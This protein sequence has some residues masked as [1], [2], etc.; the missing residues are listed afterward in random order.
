MED[1]GRSTTL[2]DLPLDFLTA[3]CQHIDVRDVVRVGATCKRLRHGEGGLETVELPTKSPVFTALHAFSGGELMPSTRPNGCSDSW[4]AYL[5]R[6]A[7][8]RRYQEA[9]P[10]A[11]GLQRSLAVDA[12]GRLMACG[13]TLEEGDAAGYGRGANRV[14][15]FT[16]VA[17][18]A[19]FRV[20]SVAAGDKHSLALGWDGRVLAWGTNGCGQLGHVDQLDRPTPALVAGL[21]NVRSI[22]AASHH[23]L[24]ATQSGAV[25]SWGAAVQPGAAD[26]L[27][28]RI[29][30]G[31]EGVRV[32]R[33]YAGRGAAFATGEAREVF[34]WGVGGC[35]RLGHGDTQDQPS[36]ERVEALRGVRVSSIAIGCS[37]MRWL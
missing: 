2:L 12:T 7:R 17:V 3:V 15:T 21:D 27:R 6:C 1:D 35:W 22:A 9:P 14:F 26:S 13:E 10:I 19:G 23:S 18:V 5:L 34:S 28:P 37:T 16:P 36:P 8:Q 30:D 29:V 31:F 25:F 20:R 24:A 32:R 4:V 33:V 11:A